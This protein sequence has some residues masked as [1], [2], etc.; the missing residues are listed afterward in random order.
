MATATSAN[1]V[2]ELRASTDRC[3]QRGRSHVGPPPLSTDGFDLIAYDVR[4]SKPYDPGANPFYITLQGSDANEIT[5][6]WNNLAV[7]ATAILLPLAPAPSAPLYGM[8]T[9]RF[10]ITWIVGAHKPR[11][12]RRL[13]AHIGPSPGGWLRWLVVERVQ[14]V[15]CDRRQQVGLDG[16]SDERRDLQAG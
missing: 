14:T 13:R 16:A 9:D 5:N 10:G 1:V 12:Y 7:D 8:L 6:R 15:I 3:T 11:K 2:D 4:P